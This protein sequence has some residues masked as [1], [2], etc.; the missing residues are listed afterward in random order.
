MTRALTAAQLRC[1]ASGK[2]CYVD[3]RSAMVDVEKA[4]TD[5]TWKDRHGR[6]PRRAYLCPECGWYPPDAHPSSRGLVVIAAAPVQC[7]TVAQFNAA[8]YED[9]GT[10]WAY[11]IAGLFDFRGRRILLTTATCRDLIALRR[12]H[13]GYPT[14]GESVA[15]FTYLHE[16]GHELGGPDE[17]QADRY[18]LAR[19]RDVAVSAYHLAGDALVIL[20]DYVRQYAPLHDGVTP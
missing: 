1:P 3:E 8:A 15:L 10:Q 7:V 9:A 4:W 5:P 18:A 20:T 14:L 12:L 13:G 11:G 6:L 17:A 19:L 16:R 2:R